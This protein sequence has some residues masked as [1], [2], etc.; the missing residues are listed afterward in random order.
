MLGGGVGLA[1]AA[2]GRAAGLQLVEKILVLPVAR[3]HLHRAARVLQRGDTVAQARVCHGTVEIP[4]GVAVRDTLQHVER[5]AEVA[6]VDVV[7][8]R[9]H[10]VGF[11]ALALART[12]ALISAARAVCPP[13]GAAGKGS[14][15]PKRTVGAER[16]VVPA[17][18]AAVAAAVPAPAVAARG[19]VF[20]VDDLVV[21]GVDLF[22]PLLRLGGGVDIG[23]IFFGQF[24]VG[25]F[26]L[27]VRRARR[28]AQHRIGVLVHLSS[29]SGAPPFWPLGAVFF[30][31]LFSIWT[32]LVHTPE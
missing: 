20:V 15:R 18:P 29:P 4:L 10:A 30:L 28:E 9:P 12:A 14:V 31:P 25:C 32:N 7:A 1:P 22:H 26:H 21:G 19:L 2:I 23:V 6:G 3:V 8:S 16:V 13:A 27:V 5:L 24:F 11:S 17:A